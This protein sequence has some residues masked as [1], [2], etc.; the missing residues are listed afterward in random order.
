MKSPVLI[1]D[2]DCA[3]CRAACDWILHRSNPGTFEY[4][5]CQSQERRDR[6]PAI[7]EAEC[8]DAM[9]L[10]RVDGTVLVGDKALPDI[11]LRLNRWRWLARI[12]SIP[13]VTLIAPFAYRTI[14]RNR[15]AISTLVTRKSAGGE[16]TCS[17][18]A[19]DIPPRKE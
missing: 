6:F 19:C 10:V 3:F 16:A 18:D 4:L 7:L 12:F 5:P 13:G 17:Q 2:G 1:Y 9:Q 14:A 11:L 8:M 15:M